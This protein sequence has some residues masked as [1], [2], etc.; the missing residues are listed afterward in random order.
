MIG[1]KFGEWR[2]MFF[3]GDVGYFFFKDI[4]DW[5]KNRWVSCDVIEGPDV[6]RKT[7]GGF[8]IG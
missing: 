7:T 5:S 3:T 8:L 1:P 4:F 2:I 6:M